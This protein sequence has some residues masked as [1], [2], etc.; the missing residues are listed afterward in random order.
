MRKNFANV[1]D[2]RSVS[3]GTPLVFA[4]FCMP[5][6]RPGRHTQAPLTYAYAASHRRWPLAPVTAAKGSQ[7]SWRGDAEDPE[8]LERQHQELLQQVRPARR[9]SRWHPTLFKHLA[10][11]WKL[12]HAIKAIKSE[13]LS[14][15]SNG[16]NSTCAD[17]RTEEAAGGSEPEAERR[18]ARTGD[19]WHTAL[20]CCFFKLGSVM[21]SAFPQ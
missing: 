14:Q 7:G 13:L 9:G 11:T 1:D 18:A 12:A 16:P 6:L 17:R 10:T 20:V 2:H 8:D 4:C 15:H 5:G 21:Q 3:A 19:C